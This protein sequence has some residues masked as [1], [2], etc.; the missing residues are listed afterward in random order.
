MTVMKKNLIIVLA[1][2]LLTLTG[3]GKDRLCRCVTTE[4]EYPEET[5]I[6]ADNGLSCGKITRL[7]FE[8]QLEGKLVRTMQPVACEDFVEEDEK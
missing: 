1:V 6:N 5:M 2:S 4:A 3:C 7:G 8:R